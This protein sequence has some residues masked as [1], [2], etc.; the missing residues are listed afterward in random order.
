[1]EIPPERLNSEVLEA[2]L[3]AFIAREGTDYGFE[4]R[5]MESKVTQLKGQLS[6]GDVVICFDEESQSCTLLTRHQFQLAS[7]QSCD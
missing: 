4:E 2:V 5:S 3:E 7:Q 6:K 1:M